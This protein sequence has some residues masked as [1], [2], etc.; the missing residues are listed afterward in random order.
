[1]QFSK[2]NDFSKYKK[3]LAVLF[4]V[5]ALGGC[6]TVVNGSDQQIS[7]QTPNAAGASCELKSP[8]GL[9]FVTTPGTIT[10]DKSRHDLAVKCT[11]DGFADGITTI[12]STFEAMTLGNV[13]IGGVVGVGIDAA[14]GALNKYPDSVQ[15]QMQKLKAADDAPADAPDADSGT[16][17]PVS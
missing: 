4:V 12:N 5:S 7:V 17:T 15:V 6:S 14:S 3:S 11:K 9:Y 1:V 10:V 13:L 16:M 8:D 2:Y